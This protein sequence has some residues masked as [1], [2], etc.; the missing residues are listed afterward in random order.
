MQA[1]R[2]YP[3]FAFVALS[4]GIGHMPRR[5][6]LTT[7]MVALAAGMIG[8]GAGAASAA[9]PEVQKTNHGH[10]FK[11]KDAKNISIFGN[12]SPNLTNH[13][14]PIMTSSVVVPVFW[15]TQWSSSTFVGDKQSGMNSFYA[16]WSGSKYSKTTTEFGSSNGQ[17]SG[18][19]TYVN[20]SYLTDTSAGPSSPPPTTM[21]VGEIQ[22]LVTNG[23][24]NPVSN[25][26][27]PVYTDLRRGNAGYCAWHDTGSVTKSGTSVQI[28]V[29][30]F[31]NLD[32]DSGCDPQDLGT[33]HSQGLEAIANVSGHELSEA[34]TD[35]HLNAWYDRQGYE[36]ADKCAWH[37]HANSTFSNGSVWKIQGNW[38]NAAYNAR[39]GYYNYG[40]IDGN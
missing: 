34:E 39:S 7:L 12:R 30:F 35:P 27:Y 23:S 33:S 16:G 17:V 32:G 1:F 19:V 40:C 22:K 8:I 9:K 18:N 10:E 24:I 28:Q 37:F 3:R 15:G 21:I 5:F 38:S 11:S 36:N 14:G 13:G 2:R 29:A 26:Y 25:G 4:R 6:A 31:F 20:N